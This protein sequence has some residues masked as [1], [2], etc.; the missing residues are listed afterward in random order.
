[1]G[2]DGQLLWRCRRGMRELD[3]LLTS[4]LDTRYAIAG[5]AERRAFESLLGLADP[6]LWAYVLGERVPP[7]PEMRHVI[8]RITSHSR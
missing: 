7:D 5:E 4:Y 3:V 6:E 1:M 2:T 8:D